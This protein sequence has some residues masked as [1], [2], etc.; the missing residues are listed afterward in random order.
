MSGMLRELFNRGAPTEQQQQQPNSAQMNPQVPS[1]TTQQ[2]DGSLPSIPAAGKDDKSPLANFHDLWQID[3]KAK[4]LGTPTTFAP[5]IEF[6]QNKLLEAA[7]KIDF[8]RYLDPELL[9]KAS[10][11]DTEALGNLLNRSMQAAFGQ[12]TVATL[13]AMKAGFTA[14]D[15]NFQTGL[16]ALFRQNTIGSVVSKDHSAVFNDPAVAPLM[17]IVEMQLANKSPGASPEVISGQAKEFLSGLAQTIVTANGGTI[18]QNNMNSNPF[19]MPIDWDT[20]AKG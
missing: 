1:N 2:S 17:K 14:Q 18:V 11:G 8:T 13:A 9:S 19:D 6:D 3:D 16:P 7:G 4:P 20:W 5:N 12:G 15:K 10:K